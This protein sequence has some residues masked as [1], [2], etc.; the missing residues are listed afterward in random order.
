MQEL[1]KKTEF[2]LYNYKDIDFK[3]K[4]IDIDIQMLEND[5]TLK[6]ISYE[7]KS[8]STNAFNSSVEN[9]VIRRDEEVQQHIEKLKRDKLL[10]MSRKMKIENALNC[11]EPEELKLVELRYFTKPRKSWAHIGIE[12]NKY[13]DS[14]C[15]ARSKIINKLSDYIFN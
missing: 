13:A 12:L 9:E 14:C 7:E 5:I 15:H 2:A 3:I 10:F 1:F 4:S 8:G 11:L 6:A